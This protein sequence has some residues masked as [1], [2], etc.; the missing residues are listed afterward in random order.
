MIL[1]GEDLSY[2]PVDSLYI[3]EGSINKLVKK[4]Y[5]GQGGVYKQCYTPPP[6]FWNKMENNL[7]SEIGGDLSLYGTA[8]YLPAK[9]NNGYF[10]GNNLSYT[11]LPSINNYLNGYEWTIEFWIKCNVNNVI[12]GVSQ[13]VSTAH[14]ISTGV[15][16]SG[17]GA[18]PYLTIQQTNNTTNKLRVTYSPNSTTPTEQCYIRGAN[19]TIA[20]GDLVFFA[21]TYDTTASVNNNLKLYYY[22]ETSGESA[23]YTENLSSTG[24]KL[25]ANY[26][27]SHVLGNQRVIGLSTAYR[28]G[29]II[30]NLKIFDYAKTDFSDRFIQ[31]Y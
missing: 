18:A 25:P 17:S 4:A 19:P 13:V 21:L 10:E 2:K 1:V 23:I 7:V 28:P 5:I 22:N 29:V 15:I 16:N 11:Y 9:F 12:A 26:T 6:I 8:S 24:T 30:D 20:L 31:G 27:S 14:L 3:G